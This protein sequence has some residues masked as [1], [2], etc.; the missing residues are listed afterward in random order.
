MTMATS[1]IGGVLHGLGSILL[2][3]MALLA[4]IPALGAEDLGRLFLTP[5]QRADLERRRASNV[6]AVAAVAA[7]VT[8]E[9]LITV[10]GHVRRSGGNTTTWIN[11]Q[12]QNDMPKTADPAT[13]SLSAGEGEA[14]IS[15]RVGQTLDKGKGE[16]RDG[17][18][19][20][21]VKAP[22][23]RSR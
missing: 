17:L 6:P 21:E 1:R 19:G 20:G 15:L 9:S 13:V 10:N 16:V 2:A 23:R 12:A 18:N 7:A 14:S 22:P 11:G 8:T 5:Q 4:A 3:T